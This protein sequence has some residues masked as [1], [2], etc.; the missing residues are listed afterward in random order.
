M[1][2]ST[3]SS[4]TTPR[5]CSVYHWGVRVWAVSALGLGLLGFGA[6]EPWVWG[7]Q[8]LGLEGSGIGVVGVYGLV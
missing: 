3:P 1:R 2:Q 4:S 8:G 7:F 6:L 5:R